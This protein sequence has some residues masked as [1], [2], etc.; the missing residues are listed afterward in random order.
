MAFNVIG[1]GLAAQM[2]GLVLNAGS[3]SQQPLL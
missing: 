3:S 2:T 1:Q